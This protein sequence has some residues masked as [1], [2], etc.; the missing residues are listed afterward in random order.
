MTTPAEEKERAPFGVG[1]QMII[2]DASSLT[3]RTSSPREHR[4]ATLFKSKELEVTKDMTREVISKS[5]W[6]K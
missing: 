5:S 1:L 4:Q 3:L 6:G 2:S